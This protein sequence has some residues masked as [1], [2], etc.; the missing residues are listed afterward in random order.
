VDQDVGV[1]VGELGLRRDPVDE[2]DRGREVLARQLG[3]DRVALATPGRTQRGKA[4][5]D[6]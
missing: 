6:V 1:V 3:H 2:R 4:R 5:V